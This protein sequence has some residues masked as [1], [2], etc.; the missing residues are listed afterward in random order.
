MRAVLPVLAATLAWASGPAAWEMTSYSDFIKGRFSGVSLA[1]DGRLTL[2]PKMDALFATEQPVVWSM[3]RA[4]DGSIYLATGHRGR[5]FRVDASGRG[6]LLWTAPEPEVFALAVDARGAL[7][8]GTSPGGKIYRVQNGKA[9]EYYNPGARY[10]WAL[11][12]G[13][14][15]ALYAGTG[16]QGK[17]FRITAPGKGEVWYET[18]QNHVTAL[19]FDREGRLLAGTEPNGILYRIEAKDKAFVLYDAN[20]PEIR[21][22]AT[23]PDGAIYVAALG[24]AVGARI[25]AAAA[26]AAG[27]TAAPAPAVSTSIT[28]TDAQAGIEIKPKTDAAKTP[29]PQAQV[30]TQVT[31]V[32]DVSGVEKSAL[33]RVNPDHTVETLWSSRDENAY[34]LALEGGAV[35]FSTDQQGR[36]YRLTSDR[37]AVLLTDTGEAETLRLL[38]GADGLYAATGTMGKLFRLSGSAA[39]AGWFESPVHDAGNVARWGRLSFRGETPLGTRLAFRTRSGNSARPD[40][41]WSDWSAPMDASGGAPIVSPNARF[42]QWRAEFSGSG[43]ASPVLDSVTVSYLPQNLPPVIRSITVAPFSPTAPAQTGSQQ[44]Q[45]TSST[46]TYSITVTDTGEASSTSAGTPTQTP[47]RT[48]SQQLKISWQCEDPDGD[49]LIY[50]VFFRGEDEREWKT[51]K[52]DITDAQAVIDSDALADGRYFFRVAA[53]DRL[54]NPPGAARDAE[55]VSAPV[56]IDN[57][58]PVVKMGQPGAGGGGFL[59][60]VEAADAASPLRRAEYSIDAG[61][62]TPLAAEDGVID[63]KQEKFIVRTPPLAAGE[64]LIVVRVYDSAGNAGLAK[65]IVRP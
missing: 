60:E 17:V 16:D 13:P 41:T 20:L 63:S 40:K 9:A 43:G 3:A 39:A 1:R 5:V 18:G 65:V 50:S 62:W 31:P 6:S 25:G 36:I 28:V 54:S 4:Q 58:P 10:I 52:R 19:A 45:Q 34:D 22:I 29:A 57:T 51:L 14:D 2:A 46:A 12:L 61:P 11:A 27:Q 42:I 30:T 55:L 7:Y 48:A 37:K 35:Y 64:H 47:Q 53:S 8:A 21:S 49:K 44:Q 32:V 38:R 24:G 33:Y 59:I 26:A 56:L 23:A 15:G